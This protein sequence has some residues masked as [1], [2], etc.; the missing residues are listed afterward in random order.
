MKGGVAYAQ[1]A[2]CLAMTPYP[3]I[4]DRSPRKEP[5]VM[6]SHSLRFLD[7]V[8]AL[9]EQVEH[10][11]Q[12]YRAGPGFLESDD[13]PPPV[14]LAHEFRVVFERLLFA[15]AFPNRVS[16]TATPESDILVVSPHHR[17]ETI[18]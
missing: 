11:K 1:T 4:I 3:L 16:N 17:K 15:W 2:I 18:Q 12:C 5:F 8:E 13:T 7:K 6:S 9:Q 14:S 10:V